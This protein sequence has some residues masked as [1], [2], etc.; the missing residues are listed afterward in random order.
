M[1]SRM[2]KLFN[3]FNQLKSYGQEID[4]VFANRC[5]ENSEINNLRLKYLNGKT[6]VRNG[7]NNIR[8]DFETLD[9]E[10]SGFSGIK[11]NSLIELEFKINLNEKNVENF[12]KDLTEFLESPT[13]LDEI[14]IQN[15]NQSGLY[16][17]DD[18]DEMC[19]ILENINISDYIMRINIQN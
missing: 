14:T 17:Y 18:D 6:V 15:L 1:S 11:S 13:I 3:F 19:D 10:K 12:K 2:Q 8:K 9:F 7:Y 5:T 16:Y 4:I